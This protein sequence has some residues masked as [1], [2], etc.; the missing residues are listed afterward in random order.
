MSK[1]ASNNG[2]KT[3]PSG[4]GGA[5]IIQMLTVRAAKIE[6]TDIGKWK[7]GYNSFISSGNSVKLI[8]LL[9]NLL[10]DP[11]LSSAVERRV[12]KIT[13]AEISFQLDGNAVEEIDDLIDTPEFEEMLTEIALSRA[14]PGR[15][16]IDTWFAPEF[17]VFSFPRKH[18][19]ITNL[20]RPLSERKR[21]IALKETDTNG[22]DY[23][24]DEFILECGKDTD[25][26]Y[27]FKAAQYAIYKRGGFGDWAQYAEIFGMPFLLGKY[28]AA[29]IKQRDMLFEAL[30]L[31]GGK[32]VAAIPEGT[33]LEVHDTGGSSTNMFDMFRKACNEEIL[34]A[35]LGQTMT[36][37]NGS[38][39]AQGEVHEQT[40]EGIAQ[41]DRR[42]VQRI[43]NKHFVP[44]LVKRGYNVA[45]GFFLFPDAGENITT[46]ERIDMA[47]T[48]RR[49]GLPVD[50]DYLFEISGIPKSETGQAVSE[51]PKK[52]T[53]KPVET[54]G[55][56]SNKDGSPS[57]KKEEKNPPSGGKGAVKLADEE[58][59]WWMNLFDFFVH[60]PQLPLQGVGGQNFMPKWLNSIKNTYTNLADSVSMGVNID[61]L[62]NKAIEDIYKRYGQIP[63]SGGWGAAVDKSLFAISNTAYQKAI[64]KTFSVEFGRKNPEF[65]AEFKHNAAVFAA[66]KNHRQTKEII[67]Q[68]LD[69]NGNLRSFYDF[70]KTVLGTTI[71]A[72]YNQNWLKTEYNMVVRSARSA[73]NFKEYQETADL[74]PNLE[75]LESSAANKRA[76]HLEYVGTIL[77]IAHPW[78]DK[79]MPPSDWG[80][81]CSVRNTD[82]PVTAVPGDGKPVSPVFDNNPGKTA[83]IVNMKEHP[84]IKGVCPYFATCKRRNSPLTSWRGAGGEVKLADEENPPIIPQ[85][86]LCKLA[87]SYTEN[88]KRIEENF[89]I[90]QQL[91][92]DKNY[93]DVHFEEKTGALKATHI[94]HNFDKKK[95]YREKDVQDVGYKY[96]RSVILESEKGKGIGDK[97]TEGTWDKKLFEIASAETGTT[98]NI[99]NALKHCASKIDTEIA[100]IYFTGKFDLNT[101]YEGLKRYEGLKGSKGNQYKEF[102]RIICICNG[103]IARIIY[104]K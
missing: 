37:V 21:F 68:L 93:A 82:K 11:V 81:E 23:T 1:N 20:D 8:D 66:F 98:G 59:S 27:I 31:I 85:C 102:D 76:D 15:T 56:P 34:I 95:G 39:K 32:P 75:Y 38:S 63:P 52:D 64:D 22:Y 87:Q 17:G 88:L 62:F 84:Y 18:V 72:N 2:S 12:N 79:H 47:L 9:N 35:I 30:G 55:R 24:Q 73:A 100:V 74:Y 89:K 61:K 54:D 71:K 29:D 90:Y 53:D 3:P 94:D 50:D 104:K 99:R 103:K 65:L 19:K 28:N 96:G 41:S 48:L 80:C 46:K 86:G 45:G 92:K 83:E 36:T 58:R 14:F 70:K 78:W 10:S 40:E 26:G 97:Y 33:S 42:Y 49:E 77:S 5:A 6:S 43:L 7:S 57:D 25:M 91:K 44:L 60:A 101:F 69:E 51:P 13:N 67:G 4:G 16:V